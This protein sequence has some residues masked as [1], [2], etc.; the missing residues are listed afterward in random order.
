[1]M[2]EEVTS[3]TRHSQNSYKN[4]TSPASKPVALQPGTPNANGALAL[5]L[6]TAWSTCLGVMDQDNGGHFQS[7]TLMHNV[8]KYGVPNHITWRDFDVHVSV[9]ST[10]I[11]INTVESHFDIP[12]N[13]QTYI[14]VRTYYHIMEWLS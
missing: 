4:M 7:S 3:A 12:V 14:H 8:S 6:P 5:R 1:M 2:V 10:Y 9:V 11:R 13:K